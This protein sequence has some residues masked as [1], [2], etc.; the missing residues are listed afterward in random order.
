MTSDSNRSGGGDGLRHRLAAGAAHLALGAEH[1]RAV[2]AGLGDRQ[3]AVEAIRGQSIV[4]RF[5]WALAFF[6]SVRLSTPSLY[7]A[8][9]PWASMSAG[10][11]MLRDTMP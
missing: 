6:G 8:V 1:P 3:P 9:A 10:S 7:S 4:R 11:C 2:T 5:A